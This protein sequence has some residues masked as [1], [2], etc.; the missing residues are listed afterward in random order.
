MRVF[1][2][3]NDDSEAHLLDEVSLSITRYTGY[4]LFLTHFLELFRLELPIDHQKFQIAILKKL[5][6][7]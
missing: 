4:E 6:E 2:Q 7:G 3:G 1:L 5:S